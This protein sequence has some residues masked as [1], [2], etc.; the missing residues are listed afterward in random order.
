MNLVRVALKVTQIGY[1]PAVRHKSA[2][3]PLAPNRKI[4]S[5]ALALGLQVQGGLLPSQFPVRAVGGG[6]DENLDYQ[7]VVHVFLRRSNPS[8]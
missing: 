8:R 1:I 5:S 3:T 4:L 2:S 6:A 7:E